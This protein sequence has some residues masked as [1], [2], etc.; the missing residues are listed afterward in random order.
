MMLWIALRANDPLGLYAQ[1]M[2]VRKA[3]GDLPSLKLLVIDFLA[4]D[5]PAFGREPEVLFRD[6]IKLLTSNKAV[7]FS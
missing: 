1:E 5:F 7:L 6:P 4:N 3:A 2:Q